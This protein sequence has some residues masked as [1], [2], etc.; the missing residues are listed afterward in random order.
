MDYL[1][2]ISFLLAQVRGAVPSGKC[3]YEQQFT[4]CLQPFF[5]SVGGTLE[6]GPG[7]VHLSQMLNAIPGDRKIMSP[8]KHS[9]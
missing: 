3:G 7:T 9:F 5:V 8:E 2:S 6:D 1:F 4:K